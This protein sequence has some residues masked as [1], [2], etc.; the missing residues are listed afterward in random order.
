MERIDGRR[1]DQLRPVELTL[2]AQGYAEGSVL[3][4]QGNTHVLCNASVEPGVPS[5]L[6][7]RGQGWVTAEYAL[8]PR[9]THTRTRR[10]RNGAGGRTQE[11]QRLIGRSLRAGINLQLLGERT[12]TVDCDVLQADGGTRTAAITGAYVALVQAIQFLRK[13]G[14]LKTS[15]LT[16]QIAAVSVGIVKGQVL[17]DLSYAEDSSAE[18][19]CNIVQTDSGAYIEIQ[20]TAE[21]QPFNRAQLDQLLA[22]GDQGIRSLLTLQQQSMKIITGETT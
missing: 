17:L 2:N 12:I 22:L 15:P 13:K 18:V 16:A 20:G 10:E 6:K 4:K 14:T 21:G 9:A 11:I 1:P 8:L 3:I 7:G 5:W 19:D